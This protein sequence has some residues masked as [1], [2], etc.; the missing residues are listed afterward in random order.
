MAAVQ[1]TPVRRLDPALRHDFLTFFDGDA[2]ADHPAWRFCYC[3]F[4]PVRC[5]RRLHI[6]GAMRD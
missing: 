5:L 4:M 1:T 6:A 2:F 3:Q